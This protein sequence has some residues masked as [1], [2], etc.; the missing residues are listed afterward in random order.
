MKAKTYLNKIKP[1]SIEKQY[2]CIIGEIL[3]TIRGDWTSDVKSRLNCCLTIINMY[4]EN[5]LLGKSDAFIDE[6]EKTIK[7]F[8]Q[9]DDGRDFRENFPYGYI[10]IRFNNFGE[11]EE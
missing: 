4:R 11:L 1:Y 2:L 9:N 6:L 3:Y 5:C 8:K 10:G 7:S